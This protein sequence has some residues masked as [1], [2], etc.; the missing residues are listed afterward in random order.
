MTILNLTFLTKLLQ[1][2]IVEWHD[3]HLCKI[4]LFFN[5]AM[6]NNLQ[7]S[8]SYGCRSRK[9]LYGKVP[10]EDDRY[11]VVS[12]NCIARG[13]FGA[14]YKA[15]HFGP[16]GTKSPAVAKI[17]NLQLLS[18]TSFEAVSMAQREATY[19]MECKH[20]NIVEC[21]GFC[22]IQTLY[23][24]DFIIV[25]E[26]L[27]QT[28]ENLIFRDEDFFGHVTYKQLIDI[29]LG[30]LSGIMHMH[31]ELNMIHFDLKLSNIVVSEDNKPKLIDFGFVRKCEDG[32]T[33][34]SRFK[35]TRGYTAPELME[36]F[37]DESTKNR[38]NNSVDV[39]SFGIVMWE[40]IMRTKIAEA[41][42]NQSDCRDH[43]R[44]NGL[45]NST[46]VACNC[47]KALKN[48][49]ED[50][51]QFDRELFELNRILEKHE[52]ESYGRPK[53]EDIHMRLTRMKN[54]SWILDRPYAWGLN[55]HDVSHLPCESVVDVM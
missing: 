20:D 54:N 33:I 32:S 9:I 41:G 34:M 6:G 30:V 1:C 44:I 26:W 55:K 38:I 22:R 17:I 24:N 10:L 42:Q 27:P 11:A 53:L 49:I 13:G 50:C 46:T 35:G 48:L 52:S 40:C 19:C 8:L 3:H 31:N 15:T 39:Y 7:N 45:I 43:I 29:F 12:K 37:W 18:R 16:D 21:F 51:V 28:L 4:V 47:P 25:F 5:W 14:I 23:V 36:V 2:A